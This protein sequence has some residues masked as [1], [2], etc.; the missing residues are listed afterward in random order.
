MNLIDT[1]E[2]RENLLSFYKEVNQCQL[3]KKKYGYDR[4]GKN[5]QELRICPICLYKLR[6][7]KS[8]KKVNSK[9][10]TKV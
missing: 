4:R 8:N 5:R 10:V 3:C 6:E 1:K 7:D 2:S 9:M